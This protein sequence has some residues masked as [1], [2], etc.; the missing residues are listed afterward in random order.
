L[1]NKLKIAL[2]GNP[3][4]GKTSL[5]N[6]LTGLRQKVANYP[7][8]TVDKKTG[9]CQLNENTIAEIV[10]L[11]GTYSLYPRSMDEYVA[12]DVLLNPENESYPDLIIVLAD[13]SNLK[14]NLLFCSQ[15][16]DLKIPVVVALNMLDVAKEQGL[17]IQIKKLSEQL[18]VKIIPINA[19]KSE[20]V[21][22]LKKQI[23]QQ[24][25][26]D[27]NY[28]ID[29]RS[30][31]PTV[32]DEIK[33]STKI[34]SDYAALLT[35]HHYINI[36]CLDAQ[37]KEQTKKMLLA[38][39][40]NSSKLQ[41]EETLL[42]YEKIN[43]IIHDCVKTANA[44]EEWHE[45]PLD[46]VLTHPL[47]GYLI[48]L[49]LMY[50]MFQFIFTVAQ[51]P[52][53]Y[54]DS[55]VRM[56]NEY[57]KNNLPDNT[58]TS[59]LT[60]GILAGLGGIVIFIPQ[61]MLLFAM[62]TLLEDS[63]YM[64][65]V[66]FMMDKLMQKVGMNGRSVVPLMSGMACA[67]PA[68][69]SARTIENKRDRLITILVTPLM[70]C[71]ARLPVYILLVGMAVPQKSFYGIISL[72]ALA[73]LALYM[74]GFV[75][76]LLVAVVLTAVMKKKERSYFIMELP[77]YRMP[78]WSNVLITMW[79]KAKIFTLNAGKIILAIA[80]VLWFLASFGPSEKMAKVNADKEIELKLHPENK[81][82]IDN[83][84]QS[85]KLENSYAG[86]LGKFI[87]PAIKPLGYD[88]KIGIAL[89][90]SFAARE[91]FVGTMSTLYSVGNDDSNNK[92]LQQKMM[93]EKHSN[94][95]LPVFS[96]A[97]VFSLLIF[98]AFAM[99]CMSTVAVVYRESGSWKWAVIQIV[100]MTALAYA[101]SWAVYHLLS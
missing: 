80:V 83:T 66:S 56:L 26:V 39:Q 67:V 74:L 13:A 25:Q 75:T 21:D 84:F 41:G 53:D 87:E 36:F 17:F 57:L 12:F 77:I 43:N 35:A 9:Y 95:G 65:R 97:A 40:F 10:D 45:S 32:I 85:K 76:A 89:I 28:F 52:M 29:C 68:I 23:V 90:T 4:C 58:L 14:R 47:W 63:G 37:A 20:G 15:I 18:G 1:A 42:R 54:I 100:Y 72:Q 7:G 79:E 55:G 22:E 38:N 78:R 51:I 48:F 99:Q 64:S 82:T 2:V 88:W 46:K 19:R 96:I 62:I 69:M 81:A 5:F 71:S 59:L 16:I 98:Y 93:S 101:S 94:T 6:A 73:M 50:I 33:K 31:Q 86:H 27:K 70:S 61:I 3:N 8:V 34:K 91:V 24:H 92:T 60:D 44:N 49:V 30:L 11:P